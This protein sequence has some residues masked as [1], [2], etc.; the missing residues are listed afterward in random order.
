MTNRRNKRKNEIAKTNADIDQIAKEA[1]LSSQ[2]KQIIA[3]R[4]SFTS[5]TVHQGIIPDPEELAKFNDAT[6]NG[7]DR[8]LKLVENEQRHKI[9]MDSKLLELQSKQNARGQLYSVV[10]IAII[11][12]STTLVGIYGDPA[13]AGGLLGLSTLGGIARIW[14]KRNKSNKKAQEDEEDDEE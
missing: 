1:N 6:P 7:A 3:Q 14:N 4:F 2:Q 13:V 8:I 11:M 9:E 12:L 5:Q 10:S